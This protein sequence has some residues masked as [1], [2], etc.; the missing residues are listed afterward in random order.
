MRSSR[1]QSTHYRESWNNP[2]TKDE[3][4]ERNANES[5]LLD[6]LEH[7]PKRYNSIKL[8]PIEHPFNPNRL[9]TI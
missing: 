9:S 8:K 7:E 1:S 2:L 6:N 5:P 3:P 4:S